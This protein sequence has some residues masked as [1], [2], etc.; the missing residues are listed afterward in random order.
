MA[1]TFEVG[2]IATLTGLVNFT[3][4]NGQ[5]VEV[6]GPLG[7]RFFPQA[8]VAALSYGVRLLNGLTAC[9]IPER[10]KKK[11]QPGDP[12]TKV[13]GLDT[14]F[15]DRISAPRAVAAA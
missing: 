11:P 13:S 6:I 3:Q 12:D 15:W 7:Y 9:V 4:H 10:L 1:D 8:G 14:P 5:D 2:E